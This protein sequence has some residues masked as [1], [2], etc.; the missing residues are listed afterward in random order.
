MVTVST[1]GE[2]APGQTTTHISEVIQTV[3]AAQL[4]NGALT[5]ESSKPRIERPTSTAEADPLE[6]LRPPARPAGGSR[7]G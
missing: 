7:N 2:G 4:L 1:D 3:L 5:P 6:A